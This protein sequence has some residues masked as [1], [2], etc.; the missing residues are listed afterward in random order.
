MNEE[1]TFFFSKEFDQNN[2]NEK[3]NNA[4]FFSRK[5]N[6]NVCCCFL[7]LRKI[8]LFC[9]FF[10]IFFIFL[11]ILLNFLYFTFLYLNKMLYEAIN[12]KYFS[13]E[14]IDP[15]INSNSNFSQYFNIRNKAMDDIILENKLLNLGIFSQFMET[16]NAQFIK[17]N[18]YFKIKC[19]CEKKDYVDN[20]DAF[21][22][23]SQE[24]CNNTIETFFHKL[25][26]YLKT[27]Y[28]N[29]DYKKVNYF[30]NNLP[31]TSI[32]KIKEIMIYNYDV[33][34]SLN[35]LT[36]CDDWSDE[37]GFLHFLILNNQTIKNINNTFNN[38]TNNSFI[39]FFVENNYTSNEKITYLKFYR[40]SLNKNNF[41]IVMRM[42]GNSIINLF[43]KQLD[44]L[45]T[46]I[47][48]TNLSNINAQSEY[49]FFLGSSMLI[50]Y[51]KYGIKNNINSNEYSNLYSRFDIN[52]NYISSSIEK[53]Y[54]IFSYEGQNYENNLLYNKNWE[55]EYSLMGQIFNEILKED[56]NYSYDF[57]SVCTKNQLTCQMQKKPNN[58]FE[59][60]LEYLDNKMDFNENI[61]VI[62]SDIINVSNLSMNFYGEKKFGKSKIIINNSI[63]NYQDYK[64]YSDKKILIY[65]HIIN[66]MKCK[67]IEILDF[68]IHSTVKINFIK[69]MENTEKIVNIL[70]LFFALLTFIISLI[71]LT[72]EIKK[73]TK[74]IKTISY[75][76]DMLFSKKNDNYYYEENT[77]TNDF[78]ETSS[79]SSSDHF[80]EKSLLEDE[81][82]LLQNDEKRE[83]LK[84]KQKKN[85]NY[86]LPWDK[87]RIFEKY[88]F[89]RSNREIVNFTYKHLKEVLE[90]IDDYSNEK[91]NEKL[92]FLQRRYK[93]HNEKQGKK[94]SKLASD[95]YQALSKL[96]IIDLNDLSYN[97]YYNQ[98]YALSQ[99]FKMFNTI[100]ETAKNKQ[101]VPL[102]NNKFI[103]F[104][105]IL[106]ILY[107][108]KKEKIQ[109]LIEDI[110]NNDLRIKHQKIEDIQNELI[111]PPLTPRKPFN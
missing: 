80:S 76:K 87:S 75:L 56:F 20:H 86:S 74:R 26:Y 31:F 69:S 8:P 5:T 100:F 66:N 96:D 45:T 39:D 50:N 43:N 107:Y 78:Y 38:L 30:N 22:Y 41:F 53:F 71:F 88:F 101:S 12:E 7:C 111:N 18:N 10:W 85:K 70:L 6:D 62:I 93:L 46:I 35:Y 110:Y 98:S 97:I 25:T 73:T 83:M 36:L 4:Q 24:N 28:N 91:F 58:I 59:Y 16:I 44:N 94:D 54:E 61:N 51:Y 2:F 89:E 49:H 15:I 108:I 34:E 9:C 95:I 79:V 11:L 106:K 32:F 42:E 47:P 104:E 65:N 82:K 37:Y 21:I 103:N 48:I 27:L 17:E 105:D 63:F 92:H 68:N 64:S 81:T 90:N 14:I 23:V 29:K 67:N 102:K 60:D 77:T 84:H 19:N 72:F 55:L 13:R 52:I 57:S 40:F 109:K 33:N 99:N 3:E 1:Q